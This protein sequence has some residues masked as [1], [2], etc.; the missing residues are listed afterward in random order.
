[1]APVGAEDRAGKALLMVML[2]LV[3]EEDSP[4]RENRKVLASPL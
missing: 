4:L 3:W 2:T 1:M